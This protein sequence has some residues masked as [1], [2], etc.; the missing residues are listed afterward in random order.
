MKT[1]AVED[2]VGTVLAHDVTRIV[3]GQSKGPAFRKG[4]IVRE[5]DLSILLDI[6]KERLYVLEMTPDRVHEDEAAQRIAAAAAGPGLRMTSPCEGRVNLV[7]EY[8]GLLKIDVDALNRLNAVGDIVFA[9]IHGNHR[10]EKGQAVGGTRIIPLLTEEAKVDRA[11][12][13]CL[14][15]PPMISIKPLQAFK[16][17]LITTG[18]EIYHGRIKDSFGPVVKRKFMALGSRVVDQIFVSDDIE[19]TVAAI[20]RCR[21]MGV[22]MIALTGGMSVD[23]DDQTPASIRAA[24]ADVVTYG[25]PTFPGAMFLLAYLGG[26]PVVGLPGCVM[27]HKSSIFE[28]IVPRLLAGDAVSAA[29]IATLGHGGFCLGCSECRYPSCGF[30]KV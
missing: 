9:T 2:A 5:T 4:H 22:D 1:I 8:T 21:E 16:V 28:L 11:Q 15:R 25:A 14:R 7:A 6:G 18:S 30:G 20:N 17:G 26:I 10:V 12:Q 23:P 29:D 3:P 24:G 19:M 27:Y 13:I